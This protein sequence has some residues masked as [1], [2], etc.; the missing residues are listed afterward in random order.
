MKKPY[1]YCRNRKTNKYYVYIREDRY[2]NERNCVI[3]LGGKVLVFSHFELGNSF[4]ERMTLYRFRKDY[5]VITKKEYY[6]WHKR[7]LTEERF[8]L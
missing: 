8:D 7:R 1:R 2:D 3:P 6:N 4:C 5:T